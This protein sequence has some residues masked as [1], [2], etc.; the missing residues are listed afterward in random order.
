MDVWCTEGGAVMAPASRRWWTFGSSRRPGCPARTSRSRGRRQRRPAR[1]P[2]RQDRRSVRRRAVC[3]T[4]SPARARAASQAACARVSVTKSSSR[5]T[6]A[7]SMYSDNS[8]VVPSSSAVPSTGTS[9]GES[10]MRSGGAATARAITGEPS[11]R[12]S[13][14]A[15]LRP[16]TR[17]SGPAEGANADHHEFQRGTTQT[18]I[19]HVVD[20]RRSRPRNDHT[21]ST[22]TVHSGRS[23]AEPRRHVAAAAYT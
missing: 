7:P 23:E 15:R 5:C 17:A 20:Q 8:Q 14:V 19:A 1:G 10:T 18:S 9:S 16:R 11:S 13:H 3:S 2:P 22:P 12:A 6:D 21:K 4:A